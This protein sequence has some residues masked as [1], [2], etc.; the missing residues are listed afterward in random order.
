MYLLPEVIPFMNHLLH[1]H[2]LIATN[3]SQ[4]LILSFTCPSHTY[5]PITCYHNGCFF[6]LTFLFFYFLYFLYFFPEIS[7]LS[8]IL[9]AL[10]NLPAVLPIGTDTAKSIDQTSS[11]FATAKTRRGKGKNRSEYRGGKHVKGEWDW[12]TRARSKSGSDGF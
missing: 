3:L 9:L 11:L 12:R 1:L 10:A 4:L 8:P 7:S 6:I 5:R 2:Q